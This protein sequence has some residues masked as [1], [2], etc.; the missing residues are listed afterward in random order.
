M[1]S[2]GL[3]LT[4]TQFF[5]QTILSFTRALALPFTSLKGEPVTTV[6]PH[7]VLSPTQILPSIEN[8]EVPSS[9]QIWLFEKIS[10]EYFEP[11][12]ETSL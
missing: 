2:V 8:I 10:N 6:P 3:P 11:L 12:R 7:D 4:M 9:V 1:I 5:L